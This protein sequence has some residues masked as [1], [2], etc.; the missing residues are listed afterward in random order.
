MNN[1]CYCWALAAALTLAAP[2]A[3]AQEKAP[4]GLSL[5]QMGPQVAWTAQT[6]QLLTGPDR[7]RIN[8]SNYGV[9]LSARGQLSFLDL[10]LYQNNPKLR[11][12]PFRIVDVLAL[13]LGVG[14]V[15]DHRQQTDVNGVTYL[16]KIDHTNGYNLG[17]DAGVLVAYRVLPQ[18]DLG[19][20]YGYVGH[21]NNA[22]GS[23]FYADISGNGVLTPRRSYADY[24]VGFGG[25]ATWGG[26]LR[27]GRWYA[28]YSRITG[29]ADQP[30]RVHL[31]DLK[32]RFADGDR[33]VSYLGLQVGTG[34]TDTGLY[35]NAPAVNIIS[36]N[37]VQLAVGKFIGD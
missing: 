7:N 4:W 16:D 9:D 31:F 36:R 2:A 15:H 18:L 29:P 27:Y 17:L 12:L 19:V 13:E 25:G 14:Y 8:A 32:Y 37:W 3:R 11:D 30:T 1:T 26:T 28:E 34:T 20:K 24:G 33:R 10:F 35:D 5:L 21:L 22:F 6:R 23:T